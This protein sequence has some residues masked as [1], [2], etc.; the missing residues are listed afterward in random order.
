MEQEI[1]HQKIDPMQISEWLKHINHTTAEKNSGNFSSADMFGKEVI[2]EWKKANIL[3]PEL[4]SF[5]KNISDF[6]NQNLAPIEM[7]FLRTNPEAV[8]QELFLRSSAPLFENGLDSVQWDQVEEKIKAS[9]KQFYEMDVSSFGMQVLKPLL[10]DIYFFVTLKNKGTEK[11]IGFLI[12]AITPNLVYGDI[13]A[14]NMIVN[15]QDQNRGLDDLLMSSIFKLIP[16]TRRIFTFVRPT[17]AQAQL[18]YATM[19]FTLN[20]SPP[21]DP[22]HKVNLKYLD[23]FE[24]KSEHSAILQK[25]AET[26]NKD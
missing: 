8:S 14:I 7:E 16:E 3:S 22:N 11:I 6:A 20:L 19:G 5:K 18:A 10:N 12:F 25:I 2:L 24:Y 23:F 26:L 13:K 21:Q 9:I 15:A 17:N 4:A 1:H